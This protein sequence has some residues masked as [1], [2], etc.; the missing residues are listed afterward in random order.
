M[1]AP[2]PIEFMI[3]AGIVLIPLAIVF[4]VIAIAV[5]RRKK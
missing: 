1:F 3:L 5:S 2:G 4:A